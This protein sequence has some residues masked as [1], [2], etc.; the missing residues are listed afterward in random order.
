MNNKLHSKK[1]MSM[2][3]CLT[4]LFVAWQVSFFLIHYTVSELIDSLVK[5]SLLLA[6]FSPVNLLPIIEF[7][8]LQVFA[9]ILFVLLVAFVSISLGELFNLSHKITYAVG[10]LVWLFGGIAILTLNAY[11]FPNSF[12][13]EP[14]IHHQWLSN[15]ALL[16]T[17]TTLLVVTLFAYINLFYAK[18]YHFFGIVFLGLGLSAALFSCYDAWFITASSPK[19][20]PEKP[21]IILLGIDSL[22]PDYTGFF[23]MPA[24]K[25]LHIDSFLQTATV[26]TQAYT[27][28]ART[29]PAWISILTAQYPK[30]S[31]ARINIA[32]EALIVTND[33]LAKRLKRAGYET[34]YGTDE[35]RF[36]DINKAYGF[37]RIIGPKS[38][39]VE[40]ILGGL[41]DFPL[42]NL[43]VNLPWGRLLFP[44]NYG[45]RAADI[46]YEPDAF[47][48]L[49]K[50]GLANRSEKPLFLSLH[51]CLSHWP[52]SWAGKH[53]ASGARMSDQYESALYALDLQLGKIL[54]L[55]KA[56]GLLENSLVVLLSDHG[57][58]MG[59]RGDRVIAE[60]NFLDDPKKL[61][62][63]KVAKLSGKPLFSLDF[64]HDYSI[65][66]SYGTGTDVLSLKQHHVVLAFK[67]FGGFLPQRKINQVVTLLDI[68]PTV[69][70]FLKLDPLKQVDGE[71]LTPYFS[72]DPH[73]ISL[74]RTVFIE[75]GE[76]AAPLET[77]AIAVAD[78]VKKMVQAYCIDATHGRL[79]VTP[80]AEKSMLKAKQR[81]ILSGDWLLARY[82]AELRTQ[83]VANKSHKNNE[84]VL[85][86]TLIP[87]YFV[88]VNLKSGNWTMNL[89]SA[90]AKASP[91]ADLMRKF[92][93]FYG[94]EV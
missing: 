48:H 87:D 88:L 52:F 11:C 67:R 60:K 78:V 79:E 83:L 89:S 17:T 9:Y 31:H 73:H 42:T 39:I 45:N 63:I 30:H 35:P 15:F 40:F 92:K 46:T 81:A 61:L 3:I 1:L 29:F 49:L 56:A 84:L 51:L 33:N 19:S 90:F 58:A 70:S 7:I 13:A 93:I 82:P 34:I 71:S 14:F 12:F 23:G 76:T 32:N 36:T 37:D 41:S 50:V 54:Q 53:F 72:A 66:T 22:R 10:L 80:A 57:I 4:V 38:T 2:L 75:T 8:A 85:K 43:L 94:D 28:L 65:N 55:L 26:F 91:L 5:S 86:S 6:L 62:R 59:E 16:I 77:D 47:L 74:P 24:S 18:R 44:Y 21:N 27:P 69:L 25:T 20:Q 64:K 68:A